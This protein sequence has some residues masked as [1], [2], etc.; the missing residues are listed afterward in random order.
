MPKK[1][2]RKIL[3]LLLGGVFIIL[4]ILIVVM[5]KSEKAKLSPQSIQTQSVFD[6]PALTEKSI[7]EIREILG[8]SSKWQTPEPTKESQPTD[9]WTNNFKK[10]NENLLIT[11]NPNTR[12]VIK[13]FIGVTSDKQNEE[14]LLQ[15]GNLKESSPDY[16]VEFVKGLKDP[17]HIIGVE[18][19]PK[20]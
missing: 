15:I 13:F 16:S 8:P 5:V 7:D 1:S 6:V 17:T 12:Q 10:D 4:I 9:S 14:E 19:L 2:R 18:V 11:F 3:P 20:K